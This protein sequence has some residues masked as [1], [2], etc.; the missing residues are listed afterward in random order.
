[1]WSTYVYIFV[2]VEPWEFVVGDMKFLYKK[3]HSSFTEQYFYLKCG[4]E[5]G[6]IHLAL[7]NIS[8]E[9]WN[10]VGD[11]KK[12]ALRTRTMLGACDLCNSLWSVI[13]VRYSNPL[14]MEAT[15]PYTYCNNNGNRPEGIQ[16]LNFVRSNASRSEGLLLSVA[17]LDDKLNDGSENTY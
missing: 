7:G 2:C 5:V 3:W 6:K 17:L 9:C 10:E 8:T 4:I 13:A 14:K 11:E 16:Q 1:M 12:Q 15:K